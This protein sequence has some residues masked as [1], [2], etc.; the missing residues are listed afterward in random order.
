MKIRRNEV[1]HCGSGEKYKKY[2]GPKEASNVLTL[3]APSTNQKGSFPTA[4]EEDSLF[5]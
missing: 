3:I 5:F 2:C 1:C 4:I